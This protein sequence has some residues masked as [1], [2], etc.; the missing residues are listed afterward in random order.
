MSK[1]KVL[2]TITYDYGPDLWGKEYRIQL[3][4]GQSSFLSSRTYSSEAKA[5]AAAARLERTLEGSR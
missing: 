1:I 4:I 5:R 2:T 3:W